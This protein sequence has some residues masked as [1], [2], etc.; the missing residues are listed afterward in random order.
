MADWGRKFGAIL[1]LK[2]IE[3]S[4]DSDVV[5]PADLDTADVICTTP[6][7]FGEAI[8]HPCITSWWK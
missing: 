6:E 4:G 2:I 5:E 1:G 7:K 8:S 3:I